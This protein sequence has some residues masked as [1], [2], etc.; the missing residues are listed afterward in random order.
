MKVPN[1]ALRFSPPPSERAEGASGGGK[2]VRADVGSSSKDGSEHSGGQ[3]RKV[4]KL[5]STGELDPV[6]VHAGI[7]D[8]VSTEVLDGAVADGDMVVIG[9]ETARGERR[10]GELPPGFGSGSQRRSAPGRGM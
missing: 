5:S 7:S 6:A 4:W 9:V 10:S 1:A 3:A 2:P 8:G